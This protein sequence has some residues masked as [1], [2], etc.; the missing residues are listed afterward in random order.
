MT[1]FLSI[2]D[3]AKLLAVSEP[4]VRDMIATGRIHP[5]WIVRTTATQ[6]RINPRAFEPDEPTPIR[7]PMTEDQF[8]QIVR[9]ELDALFNVR[10]AG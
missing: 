3:T 4:T 10:R 2:Q 9:D 7:Q 1:P 6:V 5:K 8:R